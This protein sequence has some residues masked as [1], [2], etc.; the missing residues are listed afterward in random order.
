MSKD[1]LPRSDTPRNHD[2][3]RGVNSWGG[4]PRIRPVAGISQ[5][6]SGRSPTHS[7]SSATAGRCWWCASSGPAR[8]LPRSPRTCSA[9]PPTCSPR[10]SRPGSKPRHD[11]PALRDG[12]AL[13]ED[14]FSLR[15]ARRFASPRSTC[16]TP[17]GWP[18]AAALARLAAPPRRR[19][20]AARAL[21]PRP[22]RRPAFATLPC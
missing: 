17:L 22:R 9:S 14:E 1:T 3:G 16:A 6:L 11:G 2:Q 10:R 18:I 8:P 20:A 5:Q 7:M 12:H 15:E 4:P 21:P 13:S 19:L